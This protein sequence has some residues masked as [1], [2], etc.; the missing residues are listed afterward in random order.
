MGSFNLSPGCQSRFDRKVITE[1]TVT[2]SVHLDTI[3]VHESVK[4]A[5]HPEHLCEALDLEVETIVVEDTD[6]GVTEEFG[7]CDAIV[8][9][10]HREAFLD[11]DIEWLHAASIGVDHYPLQRYREQGIVVTNSPEVNSDAVAETAIGLLF[12]LARTLGRSIR[13]QASHEWRPPNPTEPFL[14]QNSTVC[15]VGLGDV[16]HRIA[17]RADALGMDVVG[18]RRSGKPMDHV[19]QVFS[20]AAL[21]KAIAEARFV[22]LAVPLTDETHGLI[23]KDELRTMREDAFLVN[24]ARGAIVDQNA[25]IQALQDDLIDGAGLDTFV[26]EPLSKESPLWDLQN[27][28]VLPHIAGIH[29][30]YADK[31]ASAVEKTLQQLRQGTTPSNIVN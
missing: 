17:A 6:D 13:N 3:G 15:V 30:G 10:H 9:L 11:A 24:V 18:V 31:V 7:Q 29:E 25:L 26:E 27:T 28:I 21:H 12:A 19:Q 16:G 14:L 23:G 8:T 20:P 22:V 4:K 2:A 5:F 1:V